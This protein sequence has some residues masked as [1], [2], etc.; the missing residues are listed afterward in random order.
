MVRSR[1][2]VVA[3]AIALRWLCIS[4]TSMFQTHAAKTDRWKNSLTYSVDPGGAGEKCTWSDFC[5]WR[6]TSNFSFISRGPG[7][8]V[9]KNW[10]NTGHC[11]P[12]HLYSPLVWYPWTGCTKNLKDLEAPWS[13]STRSASRIHPE[14]FCPGFQKFKKY[15]RAPRWCIQLNF[16]FP[17][18]T[19]QWCNKYLPYLGFGMYANMNVAPCTLKTLV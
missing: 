8:N 17:E 1:A 12:D 18:N 15:A 7:C 6:V 11:C 3:M 9:P 19:C 14:D 16:T 10:V 2:G 5:P 13:F 4:A